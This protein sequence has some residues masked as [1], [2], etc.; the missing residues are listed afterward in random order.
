MKK[1]HKNI[2]LWALGG[3]LLVAMTAGASAFVY[4]DVMH[5]KDSGNHSTHISWNKTHSQTQ[6]VSQQ[7]ACDD[8]NIVG[9][10]VGGVGGGVVGSQVGKGNGKTAGTIAGALGG[11][12]LGKEY[13][14]TKNATCAH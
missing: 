10:V 4:E 12:Y 7:P 2:F 9:A 11:A 3:A 1:S 8:G 13:I 14:P 6:A 5:N